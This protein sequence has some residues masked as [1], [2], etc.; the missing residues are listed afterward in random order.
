MCCSLFVPSK[1][2]A[3]FF[4]LQMFKY[5][6]FQKVSLF[7]FSFAQPRASIFVS[8]AWGDG[9]GDFVRSLQRCIQERMLASVFVDYDPSDDLFDNDSKRILCGSRLIIIALTPSYLALP[10]CVRELRWSMD[11]SDQNRVKLVLL[12]LHPACSMQRLNS[13]MA[14]GPMRYVLIRT[15]RWHDDVSTARFCSFHNRGVVYPARN[16]SAVKLSEECMRLLQRIT[17]AN[18]SKK[19][20]VID[21]FSA[22]AYDSDRV[23]S[24][25]QNAE[26]RLSLAE[27]Q[28][29]LKLMA[30][31]LPLQ[32]PTTIP[33]APVFSQRCD[34]LDDDVNAPFIV[35]LVERIQA[36]AGEW[37]D[38]R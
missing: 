18:D 28:L 35:D 4:W 38:G 34:S 19:I 32:L 16:K 17:L 7:R 2:F 37:L 22:K 13:I 14:D 21:C 10:H 30:G 9:S 24:S 1:T 11:F 36:I 12:T 8:R 6:V 3:R 23:A 33:K 27:A 26:R 25:K 5:S 20:D 31:T 29:T 15:H